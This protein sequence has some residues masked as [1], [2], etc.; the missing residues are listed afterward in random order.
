MHYINCPTCCVSHQLICCQVICRD[1]TFSVTHSKH[2]FQLISE[3]YPE[4]HQQ[5]QDDL[6]LLKHKTADINTAVTALVTREREVVQ[7]GEEIKEQ[8]HTHA[9]QLIDQVQKSERHLLQQVDTIVQQ[10][11]EL[12]TK[13]R[14]QAERVHTQLKTCQDTVE[15]SLKEWS[16]LQVMME[17]ENILYQ[18]KTVN[19]HVNP[20][21]F[22]PIEEPDTK[23]TRTI[24]NKH[25]IG[26]I[27]G[28]G[29]GKA[30]LKTMPC[31]PNTLS[32]AILTLQSHDDS[33]FSLPPSLIFCKLSSPGDS[34]PIKCDIN[35][36]Q[37]GKYISFTPCTTGT[38]QLI[39]KVGG[40]EVS[41]SPFTL[42]VLPSSEMRGKPVKTITGLQRPWGIAV[43]HNGD[44]VVAECDVHRVA[45]VNKE[46]KK[47]RSFGTEETNNVQFKYPHG[48]AISNDGHILVTNEHR[49]LK[50]TFEGVC[51][52]SH[53]SFR[54]GGN[55]QKFNNPMGITVH[56]I[57]QCI[58]VADN[59][60][61][62]VQV[63]HK[64]LTFSHTIGHKFN[65]P[66]DISL[67]SKGYLY[68]AE[69]S[70]GTIAKLPTTGEYITRFGSQ[71][72]APGQ[73]DFPYSL[74]INNNLVYVCEWVNYRVSVFDTKGTYLHFF[75]KKG[76][77]EEEFNSAVGIT[78]DANH[79]LYVCDHLN[80]RIVI[81]VVRS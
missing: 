12:L 14:E 47:V 70:T 56:P 33:P 7:Q 52:E 37:Q 41:D 3:C 26:T 78:A 54:S 53:G 68:V 22:Q 11:R 24:N 77:G 13:Q 58:F 71:G 5:I 59:Y 55:H 69:L 10:K 43:C 30:I 42:P 62:R 2:Q 1:C 9:Q 18:M 36:T 80:D 6:D 25:E 44:I 75:G 4:H 67:D 64:D 28:H 48:V 27:S 40:V 76:S 35:Q 23:F 61:K 79:G 19:Q 16:Q 34:Q 8:I 65:Q 39:V 50:L 74:T 60:N 15:Q 45:I 46:G 72:S 49:L 31:S 66:C 32:T 38:Y 21:V 51:V 17:K 81:F 57:T 63:F 29:Y 73:L 20:T